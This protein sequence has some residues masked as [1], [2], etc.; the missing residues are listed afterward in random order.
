MILVVVVAVIEGYKYGCGKGEHAC[1]VEMRSE[2]YFSAL[3]AGSSKA[4]IVDA[5]V[6][7]V[8]VVVLHDDEETERVEAEDRVDTV[9]AGPLRWIALTSGL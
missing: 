1:A 2:T 9:E 3:S 4:P 8:E 7:R 6:L 5:E